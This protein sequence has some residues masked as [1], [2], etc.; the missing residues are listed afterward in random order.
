LLKAPSNPAL[1]TAREGASTAS[2]GNLCQC[3]TALI[4]KDFFFI[5]NLYLTSFSLKPLPLGLSLHA[6]VKKSLSSF[7]VG[8]SRYWKA[9]IRS[10]RSLLFCSLSSPNS[11]RLSS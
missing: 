10:P 11:L 9:A 1:N 6:L 7:L 2:L 8:P 3:L 5:S 4:V